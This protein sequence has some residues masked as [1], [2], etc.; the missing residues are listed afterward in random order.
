MFEMESLEEEEIEADFS[1]VRNYYGEGTGGNTDQVNVKIVDENTCYPNQ[2]SLCD[3]SIKR[4]EY[5]HQQQNR[6]LSNYTR[7][8][9]QVISLNFNV[10]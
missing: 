9:F 2:G 5:S 8:D 10:A 1:D 3:V 7:F 6:S 4:F